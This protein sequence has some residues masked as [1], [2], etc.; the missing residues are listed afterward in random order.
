MV[1][2]SV[3]KICFFSGDIT[4]S[5]GTERVSTMI[6]NGLAGQGKYE[7]LFL[8]L[9]EQSESLFFDLDGR[10]QHYA[11]GDRWINPGPGYLKILPRLRRF[12]RQHEI[13]IL[14]D[15]DIVLDVLSIPASRGLKTRIISWEHFD[16]EYEMASLYRRLILKYSVKRTDYVVTLTNGNR[17]RY[18]ENAGRKRNISAIYNPMQ[19]IGDGRHEGK[20]S[21]AEET[22]EAGQLAETEGS[23]KA[24][25]RPAETE[26]SVKASQLAET[27]GSVKAGRRPVETG[28]SREKW[29][30]TVG[31]LAKVKGM[32]YLARVASILLKKYPDWKWMVVGDGEEQEYL[33]AVIRENALEGRLVLTG[34]REDVYA[35]LQ[36]SRIYVMTSRSEG[37]PMCLLEA[38]AAR[39]PSVSFDIPGP[40]E[41]IEDGINGYLVKA[42]DCLEMAEKL[43]RLMEDEALRRRFAENAENHWEKFSLHHILEQWNEILEKL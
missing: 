26:E 39:L 28:Q 8:S 2:E 21:E 16:Y 33:Q 14:I 12:L 27:E 29:L 36:K 9:T 40:D 15:I 38:K 11:L 43:E 17:E 24:G 37:L 1:E 20:V 6:A 18:R 32:D 25:R 3:K 34:R 31:H 10:I 13:D 5:G 23:V 22:T 35:L 41:I 42:F 7:I 4:R 19:E 30:I